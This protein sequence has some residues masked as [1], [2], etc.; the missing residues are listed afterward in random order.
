MIAGGTGITPMFQ[1]IKDICSHKE[2]K[3][4][5][6]LVFCNKTEDDILLRKELDTFA[7]ENSEDF[8]VC[9]TVTQSDRTG[10]FDF[11]FS[12]FFK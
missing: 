12:C 9:Y 11:I 10:L 6:S 4:K 1:L 8:N 7:S 2:D 5:M 3:T